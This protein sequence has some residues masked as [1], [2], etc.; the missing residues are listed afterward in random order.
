MK[1]TV[2]IAD[3]LYRQVKAKS[4][5]EGRAIREVTAELFQR[6]VDGTADSTVSGEPAP[7]AAP[8][9]TA[10]LPAWFGVARKHLLPGANHTWRAVRES[11]ERGWAGEPADRK[12]AVKRAKKPR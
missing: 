10:A 3:D 2:D 1:A 5:L 6:Y 7:A 12:T 11:I 8:V 9:S 4:A